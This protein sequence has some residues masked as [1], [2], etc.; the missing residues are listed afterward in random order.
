MKQL[1]TKTCLTPQQHITLLNSRGLFISD[2]HKAISYLTN[3]GYFRLSAYFYPLLE[4]P[5]ENH[6]YKNGATFKKVMDMYRFDRK[7]RLL[8][9]NEIEKIEVAI[10]SCITNYASLCFSNLFWL[11]NGNYFNNEAKFQT[12]LAVIDKELTKL[13]RGFYFPFQ[14]YLSGKLSPGMDDHG[15]YSFW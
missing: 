9:F 10:R 14:Q 8:I 12:T 13:K 7:L 11:T 4:F 5:K 2:E 3:I 15:N 6:R 1:F